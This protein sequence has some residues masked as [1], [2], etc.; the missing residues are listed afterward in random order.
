MTLIPERFG[1]GAKLPFSEVVEHIVATGGTLRGHAEHGSPGSVSS[2]DKVFAVGTSLRSYARTALLHCAADLAGGGAFADV[3]E[4]CFEFGPELSPRERQE[5]SVAVFDEAQRLAIRVGKCHST[6]GAVTAL[7]IALRGLR[8]VEFASALPR[9]DVLLV[10]RLGR[11]Q[12]LYAGALSGSVNTDF[13]VQD[14]SLNDVR[15]VFT[16][17]DVIAA[18]C[19]VSGYGIAG[20][21]A[22]ISVAKGMRVEIN[23]SD[24]PYLQGFEDGAFECL[25]A[26]LGEHDAVFYKPDHRLKLTT[27]ELAGPLLLLAT[28]DSAELIDKLKAAGASEAA[29]IGSAKHGEGVFFQ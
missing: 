10:G 12:R 25:A 2:I 17:H 23:V 26:D 22:E 15:A 16:C 13:F 5:L 29:V 20:A 6:F 21:A 7:T 27:R 9:G 3:A 1:C 4:I 19:D 28:I 14:L 11:M 8:R 18:V 24:L